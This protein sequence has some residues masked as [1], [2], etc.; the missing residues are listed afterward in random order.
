MKILLIGPPASGKSIQGQKLSEAL[1]LPLINTGKLLRDIPETS[2]WYQPVDEAME[3]G[4]LAPNNIVGGLLEEVVADTK[5]ANGYILDG[6][7]R[8]RSDLEQFDPLFDWVIYF[9]LSKTTSVNRIVARRVCEKN[10]HTYNLLFQPPKVTGLCDIDNSRLVQREDD[11]PAVV[12]F[13][14]K[15]F[16]RLTLPMLEYFN[17]KGILLEVNAESD[18][19]TVA[20][21]ALEKLAN[22][23]ESKKIV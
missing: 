16:E 8:Q 12:E 20:A 15:E 6:W 1:G 11:T 7:M 21:H 13:R 23:Q 5:Y 14:W 22:A 19:D 17:A 4:N 18:P 2:I 3:M 9:K 10:G